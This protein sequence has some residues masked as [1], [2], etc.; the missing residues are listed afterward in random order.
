MR[1]RGK[2]IEGSKYTLREGT[3]GADG[4]K[5]SRSGKLGEREGGTEGGMWG[6][7]RRRREETRAE[8]SQ[9]GEGAAVSEGELTRRVRLDFQSS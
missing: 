2:E 4:K 7:G 1:E 5:E 6:E 8:V 9:P 3:V